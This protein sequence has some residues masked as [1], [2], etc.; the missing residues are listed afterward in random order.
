[1]WQE[2]SDNGGCSIQGYAVYR[3]D[4]K[5]GLINTEV[6]TNLDTNIR[7]RPSLNAMSVTYFPLASVG[8]IFAF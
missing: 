7:D 4:G 2:P 3:N 5:D 8:S 1:M 6:N